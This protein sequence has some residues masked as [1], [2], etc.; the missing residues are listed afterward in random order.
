M[1]LSNSTTMKP[2]IIIKRTFKHPI[3][4]V[5]EAI[6]N[7]EALSEWL[8]ESNDFKL[9]VGHSFKF[10]T[11][12]RGNFDGIIDCEIIDIIEPNHLRYSW[13]AKGMPQPTM[14]T[15]QLKEL[16]NGDTFLSLSHNGFVGINGWITKTML[17]FG[18][19]KLLKNKLNEY[20][21]K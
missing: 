17:G 6:T 7:K 16:D 12:P 19:K 15:W 18:W 1:T 8:M 21:T 20:L 11:T 14:V 9:Q 4:K 13:K 5:W 10:K 3:D 2:Q